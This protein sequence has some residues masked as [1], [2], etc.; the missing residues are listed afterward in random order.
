MKKRVIVPEREFTETEWLDH[1]IRTFQPY[2][3]R[4]LMREDARVITQNMVGFFKTFIDIRK[5][6]KI[7]RPAKNLIFFWRKPSKSGP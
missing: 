5:S 6:K 4:I 2:Y 7:D 1:T 3:K